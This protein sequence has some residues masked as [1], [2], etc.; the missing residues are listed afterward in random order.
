VVVAVV[1]VAVVVLA[2]CGGDEDEPAQTTP[3]TTET[4]E[5]A[6]PEPATPPTGGA[7]AGGRVRPGNLLKLTQVGGGFDQPLGLEPEPGTGGLWVVEQPGRVRALDDG[8]PGRT[9]IDIRDRVVS[10]GEQG[11][12]GLAF[13]PDFAR[14]KRPFVHYTNKDG[15]TR[16]DEYA[17]GTRRRELLAQDQPFPNHNG[18]QLSFGPDGDLYLGLGDGGS[19]GDPND[20]AQ[21]LDSKLGKILRLDP[22]RPNADWEPVTYGMRNPWRFSWDG[23]TKSLWIADVGQDEREEIDVVTDL[24]DP[25]GPNFGWPAFEGNHD[26]DEREPSG[27]GKL[28][29][30]VAE[31][32]HDEGCSVTGGYVYRGTAVPAMRGRYVYGDVCSGRI[33]TLKAGRASASDIRREDDELEGLSSFGQDARGELYAVSLSGTLFRVNASD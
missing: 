15:D 8:R 24:G 28:V 19:A 6:K 23:E 9:L 25:P 20:N 13:H 22:D 5:R 26:F 2:G 11:L 32:G 3:T 4:A 31:Y 21:D 7:K 18:G 33:W 10:G 1:V 30:P 14:N 17:G 27:P 29:F 16:V 12:L